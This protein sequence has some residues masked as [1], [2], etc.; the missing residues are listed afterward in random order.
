MA[1]QMDDL[2]EGLVEVHLFQAAFEVP[3][4]AQ[5]ITDD[6]PANLGLFLNNL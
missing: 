2:G 5:E 1:D 4:E 6:A 3:G